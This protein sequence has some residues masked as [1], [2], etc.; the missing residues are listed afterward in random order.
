MSRIIKFKGLCKGKWIYGSYVT[1]GKKYHAITSITKEEKGR[2]KYAKVARHV[3]KES[4]GQ[5]TGLKDKNRTETYESDNV[6]HKH[7]AD[8]IFTVHYSVACGEWHLVG[9]GIGLKLSRS[10]MSCI[11]VI[12]NIHQKAEQ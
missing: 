1:D 10:E 3:R 9:D 6:T 11:E 12:G 4:V 8:V 7:Y 2:D 5:F